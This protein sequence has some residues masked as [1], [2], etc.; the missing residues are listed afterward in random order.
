MSNLEKANKAR[1]DIQSIK[2]NEN[3]DF[4]ENN[5]VT[6]QLD[7]SSLLSVRRCVTNIYI[8]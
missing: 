3:K 6:L 8:K 4:D 2:E 1:Q 5:I 7:L